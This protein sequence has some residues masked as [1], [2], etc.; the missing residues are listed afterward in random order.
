MG[1]R[2]PRHATTKPCAWI[3]NTPTRTTRAGT[4]NANYEDVLRNKYVD[5]GF[6][7][8]LDVMDFALKHAIVRMPNCTFVLTNKRH[9]YGG[10]PFSSHDH[11]S[12]CMD[13]E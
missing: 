5:L 11:W 10:S 13:G 7:I 6:D 8:L 1:V 3:P 12:L 4:H 2:V 9:S